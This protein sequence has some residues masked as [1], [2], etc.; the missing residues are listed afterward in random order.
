MD[1][2]SLPAL[3]GIIHC[4]LAEGHITEAE[5]QLEFLAEVSW[6]YVNHHSLCVPYNHHSI[7]V[8]I[9]LCVLFW[10]HT[11]SLIWQFILW[12]WSSCRYSHPLESNLILSTWMLSWHRESTNQRLKCWLCCRNQLRSILQLLRYGYF[13]TITCSTSLHP[14]FVG[15]APQYK[16]LSAAQSTFLASSYK[17]YDGI[18]SYRG[19]EFSLFLCVSESPFPLLSPPPPFHSLSCPLLSLFFLLPILFPSP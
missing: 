15:N 1:E 7:S 16:V 6:D 11:C 19:R 18:C 3:G 12:H 13:V 8:M 10:L 5:Q 4:Q 17:D 2:T 14:C 9:S